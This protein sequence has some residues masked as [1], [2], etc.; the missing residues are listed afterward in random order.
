MV[1]IIKS[2]QRLVIFFISMEFGQLR[3]VSL[4]ANEC[5]SEL[6]NLILWVVSLTAV[7]LI[8]SKKL[9]NDEDVVS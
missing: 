3:L 8:I 1:V 2:F 5:H 7:N 9:K 6:K 4:N